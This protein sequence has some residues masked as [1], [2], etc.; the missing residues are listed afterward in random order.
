VR[1]PAV[2]EARPVLPPAAGDAPRTQP[3]AD[4]APQGVTLP[5]PAEPAP[6]PIRDEAPAPAINP[7]PPQPIP[8]STTPAPAPS[9][10]NE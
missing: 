9:P 2:P 10:G 3:P 6:A 7:A 8:D 4:A 5:P 1:H